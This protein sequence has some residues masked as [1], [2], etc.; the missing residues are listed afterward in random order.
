MADG[1]GYGDNTKAALITRGISEI[2]RL[3]IKMGANAET[4]SGLTGIGDLI[5]TWREQTFQ[6][7]QS[8]HA[9][10]TGIYDEARRW[11]R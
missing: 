3:A 10:G 7:P 9:D 6:K 11:M 2:S 5:V 8:R 1:L 4:L